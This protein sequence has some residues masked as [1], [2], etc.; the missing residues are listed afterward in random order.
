VGERRAVSADGVVTVQRRVTVDRHRVRQILARLDASQPGL[1]H[2]QRGVGQGHPGHPDCGHRVQLRLRRGL[3]TQPPS[4][5]V[6]DPVRVPVIRAFLC[7]GL[8]AGQRGLRSEVEIVL[9]QTRPTWGQPIRI[10]VQAHRLA[11]FLR[12]R[13]GSADQ[14]LDVAL[15]LPF[16]RQ[17]RLLGRRGSLDQLREVIDR[18]HDF[19]LGRRAPAGS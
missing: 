13:T 4:G 15:V 5:A 11:L 1:Q 14:R 2:G 6:P 10:G 18:C 12:G 17:G 3:M 9:P 7:R 19:L 8:L 16:R